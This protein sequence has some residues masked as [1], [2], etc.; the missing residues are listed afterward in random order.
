MLSQAALKQRAVEW[1]KCAA[2][3]TDRYVQS[4]LI[5]IAEQYERV[6]E[7]NESKAPRMPSVP[8]ETQPVPA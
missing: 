5:G 8:A 4:Q 1:R 3:M 7:Q 6:L 2:A